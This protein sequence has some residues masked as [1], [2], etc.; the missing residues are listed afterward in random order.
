MSFVIGALAFADCVT[1]LYT[2]RS[3]HALF[4]TNRQLDIKTVKSF[5]RQLFKPLMVLTR[6]NIAIGGEYGITGVI[7]VTIELDKVVIAQIDYMIWLATTVVMISC[8]RKQVTAQVLPELRGRRTH[9]AFHLVI[10]NTLV[11]QICA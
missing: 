5:E 9:G 2:H 1:L 8:G 11:N 3:K 7:V 10:D 4:I 6:R